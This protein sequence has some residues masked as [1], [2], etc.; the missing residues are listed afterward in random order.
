[1]KSADAAATH[2]DARQAGGHKGR[3]YATATVGAPLVGVRLEHDDAA[4]TPSPLVG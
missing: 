2:A 3:P 1:M 4:R